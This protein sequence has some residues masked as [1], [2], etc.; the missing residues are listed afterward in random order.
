MST[1]SCLRGSV[2]FLALVAGVP[3]LG[4]TTAPATT[5]APAPMEWLTDLDAATTASIRAGQP[6]VVIFDAAWCQWCRKLEE[7]MHAARPQA[8]LQGFIRVRLDF[9]R[10]T[11]LARKLGVVSLPA[12]RVLRPGGRLLTAQ[13]GYMRAERLAAWLEEAA[14]A[15]ARP[16]L[17]TMTL[18]GAPDAERVKTLLA[19]FGDPDPA[20]REAAMRRLLAYPAEV[21]PAVADTFAAGSLATRLTALDLLEHWR[22]PVQ[23]L[24]PWQPAT[25]TAPRLEKLR[26]WA[27]APAA[28]TTSAPVLPPEQRAA[29]RDQ[30]RRLAA[31][32]SEADALAIRERLV[33]YGRPLLPEV[34]AALREVTTDQARERLVLLRYRLAASDRLALQWPGGLERLASAQVK[35]RHGALGELT[36]RVAPQDTPLLMELFSDPDALVRETALKLLKQVGGQDATE[37]LVGLLKDPDSNVRAAVLKTLSENPGKMDVGALAEYAGQE[38]DVDLQVHA[39]RV[40]RAAKGEKAVAALREMLKSDSW[41][42]RAEA[43]EAL[44]EVWSGVGRSGKRADFFVTMS[45]MLEDADGFVISRA[46]SALEQAAGGGGSED[47]AL[48]LDPVYK[49]SQKH[50]EL[51]ET[52]VKIFREYP[53]NPKA[54]EYLRA[55]AGHPQPIVRAAVVQG[56]LL[57]RET[58]PAAEDV[59]RGLGDPETSVRCAAATALLRRLE[60]LYG[61][62]GTMQDRK[63][64]KTIDA[65]LAA[66]HAGKKRPA[67]IY[68]FRPQLAGLLKAKAAEERLVTGVVLLAL[69]DQAESLPVVLA[70][71]ARA[72]GKFELACKALHWVVWEK[73]VEVLAALRR[74]AAGSEDVEHLLEAL[75]YIGDA[76]G[77]EPAWRLLEHPAADYGAVSSATQTLRQLY[78]GERDYRDDEAAL[79]TRKAAGAKVQ[80]WLE[81][82]N[83]FQKTAA[84]VLLTTMD[85]AEAAAATVKIRDN[86]G[87]DAVLRRDA[88]QVQLALLQGV[89]AQERAVTGL[90][91]PDPQTR[92][93]A[94]N[95]LCYGDEAIRYIHA[96]IYIDRAEGRD[97][98]E[99]SRG[100]API[101]PVPPKGLT[102]ELVRPLLQHSQPAVAAGAGYLL[103][104]LGERSGLDPLLKH[105]RG[106]HNDRSAV[107]RLVYRALAVINDDAYLPLLTEMYREM[108]A[109][110]YSSDMRE[111]YWTIRSMESEKVA[112]FRKVIRTEVGM[113]SLR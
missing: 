24:D 7:Q 107:R 12:I 105:Y 75:R 26:E 6:V 9:D 65:F 72:Q 97:L 44:G 14:K 19:S 64:F 43:V 80:P 40:F 93:V 50:P 8:A 108:R 61:E 112:A 56:L 18:E 83:I 52:A 74:Q 86:A 100:G 103:V 13:D 35:V 41:R 11:A 110:R 15:A 39:A 46:M 30:I 69:G 101:R 96:H 113:D 37:A 49:A 62:R 81:Q 1:G 47:A 66:F 21:A 63:E 95:F 25:L 48:K 10:N 38:K 3:T 28:S 70:A 31:S 88:F 106:E 73:R 33:R 99:N 77:I 87:A 92:V 20:V 94:L 102:V 57:N 2:A 104:L 111:F 45:G 51:A 98:S 91:D 53:K 59:A 42:V 68:K 16:S 60:D 90:S 89:A 109:E 34:Y 36:K 54:T 29:A 17:E 23:G 76:R 32:T 79:A 67:W 82:K 55:M 4:Q 78:L 27:K 85:P 58:E 71:A 5:S 22:A 84:L